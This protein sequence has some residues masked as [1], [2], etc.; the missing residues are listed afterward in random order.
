MQPQRL[1]I[2]ADEISTN[3]SRAMSLSKLHN[4]QRSKTISSR[5]GG[6]S[7]RS[8]L[9]D[10]LRY[11]VEG[12]SLRGMEYITDFANGSRRRQVKADAINAILI[13]QQ[14]GRS[15]QHDVP[16][17]QTADEARSRATEPDATRNLARV[18]A[19]KS[20]WALKYARRVAEEDAKMA[21][22]I[23]AGDLQQE[24]PSPACH[25]LKTGNAKTTID[26]PRFIAEFI[27]SFFQRRCHVSH[28]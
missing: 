3:K 26:D 25:A 7:S 4:Q 23:L 21:D 15:I 10:S 9:S 19:S 2:T 11:E 1:C 18:Y 6:R 13:E 17:S 5:G 24:T 22:E 12:E 14:Q 20:R 16:R 8:I 28:V 27:K